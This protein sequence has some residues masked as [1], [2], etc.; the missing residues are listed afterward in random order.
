M[1]TDGLA[2]CGN[3]LLRIHWLDEILHD[4]LLEEVA[5][6]FSR[7]MPSQNYDRHGWKL[8]SKEFNG[9]HAVNL[10]HIQITNDDIQHERVVARADCGDSSFSIFGFNNVVTC[11]R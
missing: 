2:D 7:R 1:F 11:L 6:P 8:L 3:Q 5:G 10:G 4:A 9:L